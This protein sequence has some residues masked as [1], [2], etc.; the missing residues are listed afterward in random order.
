ML[1]VVR[2]PGPTGVRFL[3]LREGGLSS[4]RVQDR[5]RECVVRRLPDTDGRVLVAVDG[6]EERVAVS[7]LV[8]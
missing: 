7:D 3:Y 4:V 6:R 1:Q 8:E 5:V 2:V